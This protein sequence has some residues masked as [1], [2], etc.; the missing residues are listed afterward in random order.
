[1]HCVSASL[2]HAAEFF[3]IDFYSECVAAVTVKRIA[4]SS[5][6]NAQKCARMVEIHF[7]AFDPTTRSGSLS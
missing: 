4:P 7:L 2:D 5:S 3:V 1:M 6:I